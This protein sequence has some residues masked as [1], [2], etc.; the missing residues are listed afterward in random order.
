MTDLLSLKP[1][2]AN[3]QAIYKQACPVCHQVNKEG[4]DFGPNLTEIGSKYPKEGLLKSIVHPSEGISFN[5]EGYE[6]KM[7]DGS[8]LTGIIASKTAAEIIL[9][10][11]GGSRQNIKTADV[12]SSRQLKVSM[13][14][15]RLYEAMSDQELADLL[16]YLANLK[17]KQ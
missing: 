13:M 14:P 9:K 16:D 4:F 12:K 1:N 8:T 15:E 11:P 2:T 10:F 7:K 17:K 6:L 3:G 5:S